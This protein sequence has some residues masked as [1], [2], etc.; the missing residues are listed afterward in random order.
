MPNDTYF[1]ML[2]V[3]KIKEHVRQGLHTVGSLLFYCCFCSAL[4]DSELPKLQA[5]TVLVLPALIYAAPRRAT[6]GSRLVALDR[7]GSARSGFSPPR[8]VD[9]V[10][11]RWL[12][13]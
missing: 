12:A 1:L 5:W 8:K 4:F 13:K 7:S 11:K 9:P 2:L 6:R 3:G 10:N